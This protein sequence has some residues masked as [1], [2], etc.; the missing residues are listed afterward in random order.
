MDKMDVPEGKRGPFYV[1]LYQFLFP[2][3]EFLAGGTPSRLSAPGLV[4]NLDNSIFEELDSPQELLSPPTTLERSRVQMQC[5]DVGPVERLFPPL[6]NQPAQT[7]ESSSRPQ[8]KNPPKPKPSGTRAK[9]SQSTAADSGLPESQPRK[10]KRKEST[11]S[12]DKLKKK[13]EPPFV[14]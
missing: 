10:R 9:R 1:A 11:I 2:L 12:R 8:R 5:K 14:T 4:A 3:V 13:R 6:S 7:S